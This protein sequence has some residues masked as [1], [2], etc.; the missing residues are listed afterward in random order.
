MSNNVIPFLAG[1]LEFEAIPEIRA[2]SAEERVARVKQRLSAIGGFLPLS[3]KVLSLHR[4]EL[5][6]LLAKLGVVNNEVGA[7]G[8]LA[9]YG[10]ALHE[11]RAVA[12]V[13]NSARLHIA[14]AL[15]LPIYDDDEH[16]DDGPEAA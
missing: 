14:A 13:I 2:Q 10:S 4:G 11:A 8:L 7:A 9:D 16:D 12:A 3:Y 6:E 1:P 5:L 15:N